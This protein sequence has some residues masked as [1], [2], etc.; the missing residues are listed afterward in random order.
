MKILILEDNEERIAVFQAAC[1]ALSAEV[2]VW[3]NA[4]RMVAEVEQELATADMLSLDH[5]L[6]EDAGEDA[7]CGMDVV[8]DLAKRN[9]SCPVILHTSNTAASWSMLNELKEHGWEVRR[10]AP[11]T[12][13]A[14]WI[15]EDWL[16]IVRM[17]VE[18][19][20]GG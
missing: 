4:H 18:A 3:R 8:R 12:M 7:G 19:T 5:D 14:N 17:I 16:P 13:S 11:V 15:E 6:N 1:A 2:R 9:P 20:R 10:V